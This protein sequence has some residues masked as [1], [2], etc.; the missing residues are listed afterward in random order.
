MSEGRLWWDYP[1]CRP[2]VRRSGDVTLEG[3]A[4]LNGIHSV[5]PECIPQH[6]L[7]RWKTNR[8]VPP[9]SETS[10]QENLSEKVSSAVRGRPI[11]A[12]MLHVEHNS[13]NVKSLITS[14]EI[15]RQCCRAIIHQR[16]KVSS[17]RPESEVQYTITPL[18]W[19]GVKETQSS[20]RP[21]SLL[22]HVTSAR[23]RLLIG[24]TC[25]MQ[26]RGESGQ[27]GEVQRGRGQAWSQHRRHCCCSGDL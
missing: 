8:D 9:L 18:G 1:S 20:L 2:V 5:D 11:Q 7:C 27:N 19:G 24:Q 15:C 16:F 12:N 21:S 23:R 3:A 26:N 13:P 17:S 6:V 10:I 14:A 22:Q 4:R 25:R